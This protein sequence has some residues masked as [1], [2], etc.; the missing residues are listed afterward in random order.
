MKIAPESA[1]G[2]WF[3][4][5]VYLVV[6]TVLERYDNEI[7]EEVNDMIQLAIAAVGVFFYRPL[8]KQFAAWLDRN[9]ATK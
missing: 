1:M 7:G 5:T 8:R 3:I 6:F 2:V 4:A 9:R